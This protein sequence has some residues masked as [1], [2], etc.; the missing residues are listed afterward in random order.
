M[1]R[2]DCDIRVGTSGWYYEHWRDRFYPPDLP[3]SRWFQHYAAH[4]DTVEL[5][6]TFYHLP[7]PQTVE[8]W[9]QLAPS[10]FIYAVKA[11]RYI[12]HI[13][14]IKDVAQ[15]IKRFFDVV[16]LFGNRLGPVLY[17][18]PPSLHKDLDLLASFTKLLPKD[19]C[20]VFEFRHDSWYE[21]DTLELLARVGAAFCVHDMPGRQSPREV[22][23]PIVYVRFHG[24]TGRYSGSYS[25]AELRRWAGWL[26]K[27]SKVCRALYAYFNNDVGGHAINNARQLRSKLLS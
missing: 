6:N 7:R 24:S 12:T 26:R 8:R 1:A 11:N 17:Q 13:K 10:G 2:T 19:S 9:R 5:N 18:L 27:Q 21:R 4:F 22:T 16:G 14:K 20:T 15:E 25:D 3:K 23:A